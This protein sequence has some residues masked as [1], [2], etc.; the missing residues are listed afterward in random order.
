MRK[1]K[2][3][4][5]AVLSLALVLSAFY[6]SLISQVSAENELPEIITFENTDDLNYFGAVGENATGTSIAGLSAFKGQAWCVAVLGNTSGNALRLNGNDS[7]WIGVKSAYTDGK[8]YNTMTGKIGL[9]NGNDLC[10]VYD[11]TDNNNFK[12]F[13]IGN[14]SQQLY[15]NTYVKSDG[16]GSDGSKVLFKTAEFIKSEYN[17]SQYLIQFFDFKLTYTSGTVTFTVA[18]DAYNGAGSELFVPEL[19]ASGTGLN[20]FMFWGCSNQNQYGCKFVDDLKLY[21]DSTLACEHN[22]VQTVADEYLKSAASCVSPAVYYEH[23]SKCGTVLLSTFTS[24][25]ATDHS[26]E[27]LA[28]KATLKT[29]ATCKTAA[30]YYKSCGGCG[31]IWEN[32]T[33]NGT[34]LGAH[35]Y[36]NGVCKYCNAQMPAGQQVFLDF[37]DADDMNSIISYEGFKSNSSRK[38]LG[39]SQLTNVYNNEN[40]YVLHSSGLGSVAT[41]DP[42]LTYGMGYN[43]ISGK[44]GLRAGNKAEIIYDY[45][46]SNNYK[47]F[48]I[49]RY[50]TGIPP[51]DMTASSFAI[52]YVTYTAGVA[53]EAGRTKLFD[54]KCFTDDNPL[55]SVVFL[56][57]VIHRSSG[58][59]TFKITTPCYLDQTTEEYEPIVRAFCEN[60]DFVMLKTNRIAYNAVYFDDIKIHL[61]TSYQ[62]CNHAN[63]AQVASADYLISAATC[64]SSAVYCESCA[65][66]GAKLE[67][68]FTYGNKGAHTL[69]FVDKVLPNCQTGTTGTESYYKCSLCGALFS[70]SRGA[71]EIEAP[72][73]IPVGHYYDGYTYDESGHWQVCAVCKTA[74][75]ETVAHGLKNTVKAEALKQAATCHSKAVYYKSCEC[76]YISSTETFESGSFAAHTL[77]HH[78]RIE[79][80]CTATGTEE[81][82][83]CSVC[84]KYFKDSAGNSEI[85]APIAIPMSHKLG[86][87][88]SDAAGH[89]Q[90][91]SECGYTTPKTAHTPNVS[92]SVGVDKICTACGYHIADAIDILPSVLGAKLY[93]VVS[94][95]EDDLKIRFDIDFSKLKSASNVNVEEFGAIIVTDYTGNMT[96]ENV[97]FDATDK[98]YIRKTPEQLEDLANGILRVYVNRKTSQFGVRVAVVGYLKVDGEYYYSDNTV[99][100][101]GSVVRNGVASKCVAD[102]MKAIFAKGQYT[103][104][105]ITAAITNALSE[106]AVSEMLEDYTSEQAK[107]LFT[108]FVNGELRPGTFTYAAARTLMIYT[109]Y[110]VNIANL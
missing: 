89:W 7:N 64:Q 46:D 91:C 99:G 94:N 65:E 87:Y 26:H 38:A 14:Q 20:D 32:E 96:A 107:E 13:R 2:K 47:S 78:N 76:G 16:T 57:F 93:T 29:R 90:V 24:G 101:D 39:A 108:S 31:K 27:E 103:D 35:G 109:Y 97:A 67:T 23:C 44:V 92:E 4:L 110:Y 17:T 102:M 21:T 40:G 43:M 10:V 50:Y 106:Q 5:S 80:S 11:Y 37:E 98:N 63:T 36:V 55:D 62:S 45:T 104:A 70:D 77:T 42:D 34:E 105:R 84:G 59:A 30:V 66:C 41:I 58:T 15:A 51:K 49:D 18:S 85:D 72:A 86:N 9:R 73:E 3:I 95:V 52:S 54:P 1:S 12:G 61:D 81:Y 74:K 60:D 88:Q 22:A 71:N 19:T 68:T 79:P 53:K 8:D 69:V 33:F 82:W 48:K 28:S 56:D 75:T 25:S 100:T 6:S 83:D